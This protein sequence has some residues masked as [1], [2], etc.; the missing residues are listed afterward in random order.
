MALKNVSIDL[1]FKYRHA[2]QVY[3]FTG[4]SLTDSGA[5]AFATF[6]LDPLKPVQRPSWGGVP[7]L[8]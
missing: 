5:N 4:L 3:S 6:K 7:L 2:H 8:S 1:S